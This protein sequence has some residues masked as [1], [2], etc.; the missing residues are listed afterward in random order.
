MRTATLQAQDILADDNAL[1]DL[2]PAAKTEGWQYTPLKQR[3]KNL[4]LVSARGALEV[5]G[6][7][8][9]KIQRVNGQSDE[10]KS[11]LINYF[12][13]DNN[14][15]NNSYL[16]NI[17]NK[18]NEEI[19]Y[20]EC[21]QNSAFEVNIQGPENGLFAPVILLDIHQGCHI[22]LLDNME[23]PENCWMN[24]C[25]LVKMGKNASFKHYRAVSEGVGALTTLTA[26]QASEGAEY[27]H[28]GL[29]GRGGK[30]L[31]RHELAADILGQG[32]HLDINA[33]NLLKDNEISDLTVS[34]NHKHGYSTS[35]QTV[36]TI[37]ADKAR[38]VFQGKVYVAK[39]AQKTS[40]NQMS[41]AVL[42][43]RLAEMDTKPELEIYADDV[44]CAHG[45][46]TGQLDKQQLFYLRSRGIPEKDAQA[47]L[48]KA[49][50]EDLLE[51]FGNMSFQE[52]ALSWLHKRLREI[53]T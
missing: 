12:K 30:A 23:S 6:I 19:I 21:R 39:D 14:L 49:F 15:L 8:S 45:A 24:V 47:M 4:D 35:Q 1:I 40:A 52:K 33:L 42:L 28:Y 31:Y 41:R 50:A 20:I 22:E 46:T 27:S 29:S 17:S 13:K 3:I 36:K 10:G 38:G 44:E 43:S 51:K 11:L 32:V 26:L 37:A 53:G 18:L 7:D 5:K 34:L 25:L 9:Q 2:L 16:Y 48:L